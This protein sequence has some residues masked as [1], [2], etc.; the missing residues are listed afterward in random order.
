[1]KQVTME[2]RKFLGMV[3]FDVAGACN[4]AC[5][6]CVFDWRTLKKATLASPEVLAKVISLAPYMHDGSLALSCAHEPTMHPRLD[7]IVNELPDDWRTRFFMTT[8][9]TN[10]MSDGLIEAIATSGIHHLNISVDTLDAAKFRVLRR[11][12][13]LAAFLG[14]MDRLKAVLDRH[15]GR[16]AP[17]LRFITMGFKSNYGEMPEIIE[18]GERFGIKSHEIRYLF[19]VEH[20][21]DDFKAT[22]VL[23]EPHWNWL[24]RLANGHRNVTVY[25]PPA[26]Y[27]Y[28]FQADNGYI[29]P[30]GALS[31]A[32]AEILAVNSKD[33]GTEP[34]PLQAIELTEPSGPKKSAGYVPQT[35]EIPRTVN[36]TVPPYP[37]ITKPPTLHIT[38]DGSV[39][40]S[41]WGRNKF[42]INILSLRDPAMFF[43]AIVHV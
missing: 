13:E 21:T 42:E 23:D 9:M 6:F 4:L 28:R 43:D 20:I 1:M 12:G 18:Y 3:F 33:L 39:T 40:I 38:P 22:H 7:A 10:R 16:Q 36:G 24:A 31:L 11:G 30:T 41:E 29:A 15:G 5:P 19:D 17:L 35:Y 26:G 8:N 14:N 37:L 27:R 25:A 34:P 2:T 32:T